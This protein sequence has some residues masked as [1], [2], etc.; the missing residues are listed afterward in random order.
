MGPIGKASAQVD[1]GRWVLSGLFL[2]R[3][4]GFDW[5]VVQ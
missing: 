4:L 5:H 1:Y 3:T 2:N